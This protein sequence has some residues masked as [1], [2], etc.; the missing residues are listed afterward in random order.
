MEHTA[1]DGH[2][3]LALLD[4][5]RADMTG[6]GGNALS[7]VEDKSFTKHAKPMYIEWSLVPEV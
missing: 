6:S 4:N 1:T 3:I 7:A 5:L 2:A